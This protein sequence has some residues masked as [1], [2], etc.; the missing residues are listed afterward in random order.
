MKKGWVKKKT[1]RKG[2]GGSVGRKKKKTGDTERQE[3]G[4]CRGTVG[5]GDAKKG[6]DWGKR[7]EG[8]LTD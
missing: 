3:R 2:R 7:K 5:G 4:G 8:K 1:G 6:R